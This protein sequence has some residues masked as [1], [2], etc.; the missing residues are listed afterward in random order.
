[1]ARVMDFIRKPEPAVMEIQFNLPAGIAYLDINQ[2]LSLVNRKFLRQG[3]QI[4]VQSMEVQFEPNPG[5]TSATGTVLIQKLPTT[6]IMANS[7]VKG[8]NAWSHMNDNALEQNESVRPKFWT[9][10]CMLMVN[11][12]RL[13]LMLILCPLLSLIR[14]NGK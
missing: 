2:V 3:M 11:I 13:V 9:I 8:Y 1:M 6:W 12:M 14:E 5:Q 7:W 4:P 10:K